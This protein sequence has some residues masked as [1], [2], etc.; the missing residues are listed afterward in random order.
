MGLTFFS[1]NW[2]SACTDYREN[3]ITFR[4]KRINAALTNQYC[5]L[6]REMQQTQQDKYELGHTKVKKCSVLFVTLKNFS[7]EVS[8]GAAV[9]QS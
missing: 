5:P 2:C 8:N 7:A 1:K 9:T 3:K 4:K 6:L